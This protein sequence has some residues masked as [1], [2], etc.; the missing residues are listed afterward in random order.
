MAK[1]TYVPGLLG[2]DEHTQ[3]IIAWFF[4]F[5]DAEMSLNELSEAL[6][7]SKITANAAVVQLQKTE[8][9]KIKNIGGTWQ[10]SCNKQHTY[11]FTKKIAYNLAQIYNSKIIEEVHKKI[12]H[13]KAIILF[14]SYRKG[15][16]TEKSDIDI[17]VEVSGNETLKIKELM[18]L[19]TFGYRKNVQVN[20]HVF[21]RKHT[22]INLFSN[23]ANG[24]ILEGFL[25]VKP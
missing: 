25:E 14:G 12:P 21:S 7:M 22:D 19:P 17:A 6:K 18:I 1:K 5:P 16:D 2:N 13:A 23:I 24:I 10:I 3:K 8:F 20:L 4:A 11:N 9:I 15:D